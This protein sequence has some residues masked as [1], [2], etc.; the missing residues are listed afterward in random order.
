MN[1][2]ESFEIAS[3]GKRLPA[4]ATGPAATSSRQQA[5]DN[6]LRWL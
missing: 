1:E 4:A 5:A 6:K 3:L 2:I